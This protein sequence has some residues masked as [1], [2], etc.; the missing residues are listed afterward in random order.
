MKHFLLLC[1]RPAKDTNADTISEHIDSLMQIPGWKTFELSMISDIP[2]T[3]DLSRFEAIGIHYTIHLS[4]PDYHYL[5]RCS[6]NALS[7]FRGLKC[8]WMH[9]EYR[10]VR[11]VAETLKII[12]V[13][14]IFSLTSTPTLEVLYPKEILPRTTL[15]T[16]FAGYVPN[17]LFV[18]ETTPISTRPIDV[19]YRTRRPPYWLGF[20]G[21]E[22]I[23]IGQNFM[24]HPLSKTLKLNISVEEYD[25][26]YGKKWLN[27][28]SK[29]KAVLCVESGSSV[30]DFS[31]S[32]ETEVEKFCKNNKNAT[33]NE[34]SK[35]YLTGIDG[36]YLINTISPRV[37]EA[38]A[39]KTVIIAFVGK[40]SGVIEPWVHYIPLEKDFSNMFKV[41]ESIRNLDLM[42][43]IA[44]RTKKDLVESQNYSYES[45][46]TFCGQILSQE[47]QARKLLLRQNYYTETSFTKDLL[48]SPKYIAHKYGANFLQKILLGSVFRGYMFR[49][50]FKSPPSLRKLIKPILKVLGR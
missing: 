27:L 18:Q 25:R 14:V 39:M 13:D 9:D 11:K 26:V 22:K 29:S 49:I 37:F 7:N 17:K 42:E 31:G 16:I 20:L 41:T 35:S 44:E 15:K 2:K 47:F 5:S 36:K 24:K 40:Y 1:N 3:I 45:F 33:F 8:V 50:W 4:D 32:I 19:S 43:K 21:Q 46:S 6:I 12:G 23:E 48:L 10:R 34:I 30:I 28:L 38:A